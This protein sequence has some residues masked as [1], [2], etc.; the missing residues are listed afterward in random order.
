MPSW[1]RRLQPMWRV[2]AGG[3]SKIQGPGQDLGQTQ[4]GTQYITG[5]QYICDIN[6]S[7][8]DSDKCDERGKYWQLWKLQKRT[9]NVDQASREGFCA[10]CLQE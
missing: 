2:V 5:P 3:P 10:C 4:H 6:Y 9:I 7:G 1:A 8:A